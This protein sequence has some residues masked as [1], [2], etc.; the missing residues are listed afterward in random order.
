[1]ALNFPGPYELRLFYTTSAL[2]GGT[3]THVQ[4]LNIA[5]V[6][7]VAQGTDFSA[8]TIED[9]GGPAP[10]I[11]L[12]F[13]VEAYLAVIAPL[14]NSGFSFD[15]VQL[16]KY[17]TAQSFD[18][19]FWSTY[20][21]PTAQPSSGA[22]AQLNGQSIMVLRS[23]EGGTMKFNLM[24]TISAQDLPRA[25]SGM[26]AAWQAVADFLLTGGTGFDAPFLARDTSYP[27]AVSKLFNGQNEALFKRRYRK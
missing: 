2:T 8:I 17:P 5:L 21:P 1:M 6:E 26:A 19:E 24:E 11:L 15:E 3:I 27:F 25:Y 13:V 23:S 9:K 16:W 18:S 10:G 14:F 7:P 4:H 20:G 12:D 22:A